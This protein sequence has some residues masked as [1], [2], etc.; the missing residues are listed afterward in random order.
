M[1]SFIYYVINAAIVKLKCLE[2]KN[3]QNSLFLKTYITLIFTQLM[4]D[5]IYDIYWD[6]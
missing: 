2:F 3:N 1:D 6:F 5:G 4:C